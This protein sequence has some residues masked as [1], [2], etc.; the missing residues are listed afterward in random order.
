[1][2]EVITAL[3]VCIDNYYG[4]WKNGVYYA[5]VS[6]I[7]KKFTDVYSPI[8]IKKQ[9]QNIDNNINKRECEDVDMNEN[10]DK[11]E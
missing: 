1:M 4:Y 5:G 10:K 3:D 7:G 6:D 9:E 8:H 2:D 11:K